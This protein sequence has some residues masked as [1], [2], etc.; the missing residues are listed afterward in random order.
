M[1]R[2]KKPTHILE[3]QG[4]LDAKRRRERAQEPKRN[5]EVGTPPK[6]L[7]KPQR[8]AWNELKRNAATGVFAKSD[9]V[10][11]EMAAVLLAEFRDDPSEMITSRLARLDSL[12]SR[13]GMTPSDRAKV[14]VPEEEETT[15]WDIL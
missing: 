14:T 1:G 7:T 6:H 15:G 11:L 2:T 4:H 10:A 13:F 12:L 8:E 5:G 9:R 3:L